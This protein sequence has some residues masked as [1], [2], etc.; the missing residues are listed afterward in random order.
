MNFELVEMITK[1]GLI[2]QGMMAHP[3][4]GSKKAVLWVHGLTGKF[5][6]NVK[7]MNTLADAC[8]AH[9]MAFASFNTR[10]HDVITDLKKVDPNEPSGYAHATVGG[11]LEVFTESVFDIDAALT[12]LVSRGYSEVTIVGHSTGAN[13]VC[14]YA[15]HTKDPRVVGVVLAGPM[16]DRL[17]EQKNDKVKYDDTIKMVKDLVESGRGNALL[18]MLEFPM[19]AERAMS[20]LT[21]NTKED[22]FNYGDDKDVLPVFQKITAPLFV[23]LSGNDETGDRPAEDIRKVFDAHTGS[24]TYMS[25]VMKDAS[26]GYDGKQKEFSDLVVSWITSLPPAL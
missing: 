9:G 13:K 18:T 16:S 4:A 24:K 15:A 26:H 10:G 14:Y 22:V 8:V 25:I 19:L 20:L 17:Y 12:Y 7:L 21:P 5:Y 23:V 6:G 11:G 1:D 3:E 2:H